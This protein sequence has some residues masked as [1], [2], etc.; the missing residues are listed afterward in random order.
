MPKTYEHTFNDLGGNPDEGSASVVDLG[1]QAVDPADA[2]G[3]VTL[4]QAPGNPDAGKS[5]QFGDITPVKKDEVDD[6][7]EIVAG[8]EPIEDEPGEVEDDDLKGLSKAA[9]ER[10]QRERRLRQD[11]EERSRNLEAQVGNINAKLDLQGKESEWSRQDEKDDA[12]LSDLRQQKIKAIE[13]GETAKAVDLDDKITDLKAAKRARETERQAARKAVETAVKT[14]GNPQTQ[15]V[16]PKA[17]AWIDAHPQYN[18]DPLFQRAARNADQLL[19]SKGYNVNSDE[20]YVQLTR[21]LSDKFEVSP[22]YLKLR[23]GNKTGQGGTGSNGV[24]GGANVGQVRRGDNGRTQVTVTKEDKK[25][26][27]SMGQDPDDPNVIRAF[28]REKVA[29]ERANRGGER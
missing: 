13:D 1:P 20:Y 12:A 26:L 25:F 6:G 17:K 28:A 9:Q 18:T 19:H 11:A 3:R 8:E 7:I 29:M 5:D 16:H 15:G 23:K 22:D 27:A 21:L 24:R 2:T 14:G 10:I 4:N